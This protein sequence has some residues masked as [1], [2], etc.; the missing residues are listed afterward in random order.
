MIET[1]KIREVFV[2]SVAVPEMVTPVPAVK[3]NVPP[4]VLITV[5]V[6]DRLNRLGTPAGG[7]TPAPKL[8]IAVL[9]AAATACCN[10]AIMF[11]AVSVVNAVAPD[12]V[13]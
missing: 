7:L 13:I 1:T 4:F 8:L 2:A 6:Y 11:T 3:V 5:N 9:Y 12:V 10:C